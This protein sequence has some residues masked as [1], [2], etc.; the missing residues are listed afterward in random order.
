MVNATEGS[1]AGH[2]AEISKGDRFKFGQ[3]WAR[4]IRL[5]DD[6]RI[7][8]AEQSLASMLGMDS[9]AGKT[10]L[11][12]G[13]GS[14]LFSL[15]AKRLGAQ[16]TSFDYDP[17]SVA[18]ALE[19]RRRYCN[20]DPSWS[21]A[22]GSVLDRGYV[23]SLGAY[24]V[25]YSWGVLH[26]TG[27]M[28][29]AI[30]QALARVASGGSFFIA[31]Y[32]HQG[33]ISIYWKGVKRLYNRHALLRPLIVLWHLPYLLGLRWL[34]R[35]VVKRD[36]I[37]DRGMSLW[38]DM[39]DWLGGHPFEVAKPEEIIAFCRRHGLSLEKLTTC[40]GRHGCNQF[41]FRRK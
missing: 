27:A 36:K 7:K 15:A 24:E 19:L 16:V 41:V 9:L 34:V 29:Q 8:D 4:F 31:I 2:A 30:E 22:Q 12:I 28:W 11:D 35:R 14:G 13:S 6:R 20:D 23:E 10:F 33:W 39:I 1:P 26:H 21:I 37:R 38:Y 3:N 18:C 17:Q 25:V 5:L 40:G 32:N